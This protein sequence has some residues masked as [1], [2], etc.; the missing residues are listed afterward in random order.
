[1]ER[2]NNA[3]KHNMCL[4]LSIILLLLKIARIMMCVTDSSLYPLHQH[5]HNTRTKYTYD[6]S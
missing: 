6:E 5:Q 1:M 4:Q 3:S 2:K